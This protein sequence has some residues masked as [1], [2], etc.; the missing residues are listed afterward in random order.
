MTETSIKSKINQIG[1]VTVSSSY[2]FHLFHCS[3]ID[4]TKICIL[5]MSMPFFFY[6]THT[7]THTHT[8]ITVSTFT[9]THTHTHTH[10]LLLLLANF[11]SVLLLVTKI[12]ALENVRDSKYVWGNP[13]VFGS[14]KKAPCFL[15]I[16]NKTENT[17]QLGLNI[18][19]SFGM[20]RDSGKEIWKTQKQLWRKN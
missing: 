12:W 17:I 20:Q 1:S 7:H 10:K 8:Q 19:S 4:K 2:V 5:S 9:H 11:Y 18:F 3:S 16:T 13:V 6:F 14:T 15:S